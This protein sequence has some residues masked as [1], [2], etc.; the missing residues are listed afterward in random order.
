[1]RAC[2]APTEPSP[3]MRAHGAHGARD[4]RTG[5]AWNTG[6]LRSV[7]SVQSGAS[8]RSGGFIAHLP[9]RPVLL[10]CSRDTLYPTAARPVF[11]LTLDR[12]GEKAR[13]AKSAWPSWCREVH[14]PRSNDTLGDVR[15]GLAV[16]MRRYFPIWCGKCVGASLS[17]HTQCGEPLALTLSHNLWQ[18]KPLVV[19]R[20]ESRTWKRNLC[21][22]TQPIPRPWRVRACS[23]CCLVI[24]VV[25]GW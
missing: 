11:T 2:S 17:P 9:R 1:M 18:H 10:L 8:C 16:P 21:E 12:K 19:R 15:M 14:P 13:T 22:A 5:F 4:D 7:F 20:Q 6:Y 3:P 23:P 24:F 25:F